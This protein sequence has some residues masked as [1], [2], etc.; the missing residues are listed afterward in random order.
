MER[1]VQ[2]INAVKVG[3]LDRLNSFAIS[4]NNLAEKLGNVDKLTHALAVQLTGVLNRLV[5]EIERAEKTINNA[6]KMQVRRFDMIK[7]SV[8]DVQKIMDKKLVVEV[9]QG[10][11]ADATLEGGGTDFGG[12]STS[13]TTMNVSA[14]SGS[15]ADTPSTQQKHTK[16]NGSIGL[17]ELN[18][19]LSANNDVLVRKLKG[20]K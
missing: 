17:T 16:K 6:D 19:A 20:R 14:P 15:N 9:N 5:K 13:N 3:N 7:K 10:M 8:K 1:Y 11:A 2:T 4:L 18:E 12:A